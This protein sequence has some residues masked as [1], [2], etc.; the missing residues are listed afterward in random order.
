MSEQTNNF[1][2]SGANNSGNIMKELSDIKSSL[3]TNTEATANIKESVGKVETVVKDMQSKYITQEHLAL[4]DKTYRE[5]F[6][7]TT[8]KTDDHETRIRKSETNITKIL[9]WGSIAAFFLTA[10]IA[11]IAAFIKKWL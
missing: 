5:Q 7:E 6:A 10:A 2:N 1:D 3:A 8:K 4:L 9:T 11:L